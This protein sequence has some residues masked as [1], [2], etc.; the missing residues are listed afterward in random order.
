[1]GVPMTWKYGCVK[2]TYKTVLP[3]RK[4]TSETLYELVEVYDGKGHTETAIQ[5]C[6]SS[7]NKLIESLK[8]ALWDLQKAPVIVQEEPVVH[9]WDKA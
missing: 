5:M 3:N 8:R 7:K 6:A 1:M 4:V 9:R 2:R